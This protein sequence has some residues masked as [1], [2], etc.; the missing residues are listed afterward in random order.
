MSPW[1]RCIGLI[2]STTSSISAHALEVGEPRFARRGCGDWRR[3]GDRRRSAALLR[4]L[5]EDFLD[6]FVT[7]RTAAASLGVIG[8][9]L[10]GSTDS[11]SQMYFSIKHHASTAKHLRT[12]HAFGVVIRSRPRRG[13]WRRPPAAPR[14][15]CIEQCIFSERQTVEVVGDF[16][17]A[18]LERFVERLALDD[19]D[20]NAIDEAIAER[21]R[22]SENVHRRSAR[23]VG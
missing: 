14:A 1:S 15:P 17:I 4:D 21:N 20:Y 2:D 8:H 16:L 7:A 10:D 5:G 22:R 11:V 12:H 19:L 18:D 13:N 6:A 9:L 23:S 3:R